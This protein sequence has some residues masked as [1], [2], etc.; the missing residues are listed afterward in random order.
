M[1][2][3]VK[4]PNVKLSS[5]RASDLPPDA[6]QAIKTMQG[7]LLIA[8]VRRLGGRVVMPVSEV[9]DTGGVNLTMTIDEGVLIFEVVKK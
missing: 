8:L 7:Q 2:K 4:P 3:P 6:Q 5:A 1:I 9:D